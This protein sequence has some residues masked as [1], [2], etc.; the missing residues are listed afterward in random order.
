MVWPPSWRMATSKDTRVRV[1]GFS[2]II[3]EDGGLDALRPQ[4]VGHALAGPLHGVRRVDNAAQCLGVDLVD[5][6]EVADGH[7]ARPRGSVGLIL[8]EVFRLTR[9]VCD[10]RDGAADAVHCFG[11]LVFGDIERRQQTHDVVAGGDRQQFFGE[12]R[13]S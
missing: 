2:K 1:D 13:P 10:A 11:Q 6:E 8:S 5:I 7:G 3:G 4:A 12:R 9:T